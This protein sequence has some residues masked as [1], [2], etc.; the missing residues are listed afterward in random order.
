MQA[1]SGENL[2]SEVFETLF[3]IQEQVHALGQNRNS[4][5]NRQERRE[6]VEKTLRKGVPHSKIKLTEKENASSLNTPTETTRSLRDL[7]ISKSI[8]EKVRCWVDLAE[9]HTFEGR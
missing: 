5:N 2:K 3:T 8:L 4:R 9:S 1:S 7:N 6:S